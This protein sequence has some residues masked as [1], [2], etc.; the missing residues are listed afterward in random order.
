[1]RSTEKLSTEPLVTRWQNWQT[2]W[3]TH[4]K[5]HYTAA[6]Q[7][8]IAAHQNPTNQIIHHI[9]NALAFIALPLLF[10]DWRIA[11]LLLL[12]PQPF[13]WLG[14]AVFE[15]N[16]PA[17]IKYPGTTILASLHWSLQERFGLKQE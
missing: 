2:R 9:T 13:V 17:F 7:H 5:N 8:F 15:K 16:E 4:W 1:M 6:Q 11:L 10:V 14:H 12:L 3:Q